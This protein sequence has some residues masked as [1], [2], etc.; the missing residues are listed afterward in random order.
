M[1]GNLKPALQP[2]LQDNRPFFFYRKIG[3]C[4]SLLSI[5]CPAVGSLPKIVSLIVL[6]LWGPAMQSP[7][8]TRAML[9]SFSGATEVPR[10]E[11][12]PLAAILAMGEFRTRAT[13]LANMKYSGKICTKLLALSLQILCNND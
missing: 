12:S 9:P 1:C 11:A 5:P 7:V 13:L 2:M 6:V 10:A 3:V 4:F 8:V